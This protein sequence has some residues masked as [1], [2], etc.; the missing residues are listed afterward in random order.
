MNSATAT[1]YEIFS[2]HISRNV[3]SFYWV[4]T[5]VFSY[6]EFLMLNNSDY[7]AMW[8]FLTEYSAQLLEKNRKKNLEY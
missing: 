3:S 5:E 7:I 4:L 6:S 8:H 1:H 2:L